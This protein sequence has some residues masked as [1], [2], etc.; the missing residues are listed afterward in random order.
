M[1]ERALSFGAGAADYE[2]YRPGYPDRLVD[3]IRA[4]AGRPLRTA[5]EIGA[6]T[7]KATR[8]FAAAG[9]DVLATDPDERHARGAAPARTRRRTD[10][11]GAVRGAGGRRDVRPGVRGGRDALD[12]P[13]GPL[14]AGGGAARA[15]RGVRVVRRSRSALPTPRS[16]RRCATVREPFLADDGV[17]SPDGTAE[18]APMQWPGSELVA[19]GRASPT[20]A[21]SRS[22]GDC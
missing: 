18:D 12:R 11:A 10:A 22:S 13:G 9:I 4:Y 1:T 2:R 8:V 14:A 15:R 16:R 17:A 6:G 5:L 7:G 20:Y 19:C 21:R 3:T